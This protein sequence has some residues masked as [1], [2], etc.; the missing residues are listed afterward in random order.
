MSLGQGQSFNQY[1]RLMGLFATAFTVSSVTVFGIANSIGQLVARIVPA[2]GRIAM[3]LVVL[4]VSIAIDGYTIARKTWCPATPR[5]QTP[6]MI[7]YR[8]GARRAAVAWGLDTGLLLTTYR[9]SSMSWA[10]LLFG[11]MGV[12][13]WWIG[14]AYAAGFVVPLWLGSSMSGKFPGDSTAVARL[15]TGRQSIGRVLC[16]GVGALVISI[17]FNM[18]LQTGTA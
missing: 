11:L 1:M 12:T 13:P 2:D 4:M 6:K 7:Y 9:V 5:R 10:L 8:H 14:L 3:A 16:M 18:F 15:L 17:T